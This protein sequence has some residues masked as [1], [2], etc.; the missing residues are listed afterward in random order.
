MELKSFDRVAHIYDQTR[1]MPPDVEQAIADG[2]AGVVRGLGAPPHLLEV[3]I[4]TGRIAVPLAERGVRITGVD[5]APKMLA[6]LRE[7]RRDIALLFAEAARL[8]FRDGTFDAALF[9]HVLHLVPDVE[10]T[11]GAA[12]AAVRPGGMMLF[13]GEGPRVGREIEM[14]DALDEIINRYIPPRDPEVR[15]HY[16]RQISV[17]MVETAG[18][19]VETLPLAT[20]D[21]VTSGREVLRR[22]REKDNSGSWHIPDESIPRIVEESKP[23]LAEMFGGLDAPLAFERSFSLTVG[24]L[25]G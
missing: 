6:R 23:V 7:K 13:G 17:E 8:P 9:V 3:G 1:A 10:A 12:M 2:I 19:T 5:V 22:L 20:W 25:P 21:F 24:R 18:G 11:I 14:S 15:D 16:G 4:G